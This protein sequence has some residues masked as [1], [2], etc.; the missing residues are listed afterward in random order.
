MKNKIKN[1]LG[2]TLVEILIGIVI[3]SIMMAAMF[4]SYNVVRNTYSQVTDVAGISRSGRD[5]ISMMM[6]DIRMAG[7]K[8]QYGVLRAVDEE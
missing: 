7:F 2:F 3:S 6:R 8:Y 5:I 1:I 4:T